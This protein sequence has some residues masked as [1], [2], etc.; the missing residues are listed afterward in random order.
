M[1]NETTVGVIIGRFQVE[2]LHGGHRE[3]FDHVLEQN[4]NLNVVILGK[5]PLGVPT[6][7]NPLDVDARMRMIHETYSGKFVI[8]WI[9]DT[10]GDDREW[11]EKLD[12][13]VGDLANGRDV[14][15]YGSRDSFVAHYLGKHPTSVYNQK[16][17]CSATDVRKACGKNV[18][19]S[20][21]WRAGVIW[22]TQNQF[23]KVYPTVDVA[24]FDCAHGGEEEG[25]IIWLGK[26]KGDD[27]YRFIG[28]FADPTDGSFE[29]AA[30]REALEETGLV[31]DQV[32]YV[33]SRRMDDYRYSGEIDKI[34]T[35]FY[36][37]HAASG[38]PKPSDDIAE[39]HR[40]N[41][42]DLTESDIATVH[43]PLFRMLKS[44]F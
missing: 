27:G 30:R 15:L 5:T 2:A 24:I 1:Q 8:A 14:M 28:G 4:H 12:K 13:I 20:E 22:A 23:D 40:L 38:I 16:V 10:P 31:V 11:S 3:L 33:G 7:R 9:E 32:E 6:K 18:H 26:K 42:S 29:D 41:F 39:L 21:E 19:G 37:A 43:R 44:C 36:K 25:N 17:Y 35:I 34:I